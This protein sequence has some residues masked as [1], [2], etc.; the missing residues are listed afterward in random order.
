MNIR[1]AMSSDLSTQLLNLPTAVSFE[2]RRK[3]LREAAE[4]IRADAAS[5]APRDPTGHEPHL[6]DHIIIDALTA[7]EIER[8][9]DWVGDEAVVE[10]GPSMTTF[11]GYFSEFGT[12]RQPSTPWFRP[13]FDRNVH[14]ALNIFNA[15]MWEALKKGIGK[16][17]RTF[18]LP[19]NVGTVGSRNL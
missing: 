14:R 4:P 18:S 5:N 6:A 1:V 2:V 7:A 9:T 12:S 17:T 19:S 10:I 11:W 3:A 13:A 8:G 15:R 16:G